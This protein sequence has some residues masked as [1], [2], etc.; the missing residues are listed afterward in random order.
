MKVTPAVKVAWRGLT[1]RFLQTAVIALVVLASTA[2]SALALGMIAD[3]NAPFDHAF[4]KDHGAQVA[5]T[6]DT[7]TASAAQL[8]ATTRLPGVTA[9][10]GPFPQTQVTVHIGLSGAA[11]TLE[12]QLLVTGRASPGGP[13]D[14]LSLDAGRWA[15]TTG[16]IVWARGRTSVPVR[17]GQKITVTGVPGSPQLTVV[18]IATSVTSTSQAW[19][20]PAEISA[21][22]APG[23]AQMLYRF[24]SAGSTAA[25][26]ADIAAV[27]AA[28]PSGA[29]LGAPQ[30]YLPVQQ[31]A[32]ADIAPWVP[33][34]VTFGVIALVMSVLIVI[35]VISGAV[36]GGMRRIGV[37]KSIGFTPL[38]VVAAYVL[39]VAIPALV[40]CVVGAV[41]GDLLSVPLLNLNG[42]VYGIG[43]LFIP[44]W[45]VVVVPLA[46]LA[47]TCAAATVPALRA[48]RM[49][50]VQAIATGRAPRAS[51]GFVA[52]RLL[53]RLTWVPRPVTIGLAEPFSRPARTLVTLAAILFGVVA[54]TF[55]V[56]LGT[57]LSRTATDLSL[58]R[59]EPVHVA[60]RA[61]NLTAGQQ[62]T[63]ISALTSQPGTLHDVTE[64]DDQIGVPGLSSPM[65]V[66]SYDG[67]ASWTGWSVITGRW[68]S[69]DGEADV[70]TYFLTATGTAVGDT[71]T[72]AS[73]GR[74]TTVR[75]VGEVFDTGNTADIFMS[76]AS[77][78]AVAPGLTP[79]QYD[80]GVR[81]GTDV[82]SYTNA[83]STTLGPSFD[84]TTK[85]NSPVFS[86]VITLLAVL[87]VLLIVVAGLG[88]LNTVVL[89]VRERAH[90]LGIFKAIGMTPRQTVGMVVCS[91]TGIGLV[92]G[93]I[94]IPAGVALH[95]YV[96]P[97][98]GH[99]AQ[100]AV[101]GSLLSVYAPSE[102]ALLALSG[103]LIAAA[104]ALG[105]ASWVAR[106]RT[107]TALRAE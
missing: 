33:F 1:G 92:A 9:A 35:N 11:G 105:P 10:A 56:G 15:K 49:S 38:G 102:L 43:V 44:I 55:G 32:A 58:A 67:D 89:Q 85:T 26:S 41:C 29:L 93:A 84:V 83:L 36:V 17:L 5:V 63:I 52:H 22:H 60:P 50:A 23:V 95:R 2:A 76:S 31:E 104:G 107:A 16:E 48:G 75:I 81:P 94:A 100:S 79:H 30:S 86:S 91:V 62:Q 70:N 3:T 37:L 20:L 82:Q 24:S 99:A 77:L 64:T 78:A 47:L 13:V 28:L 101:P 103:L 25:V 7:S 68:Y 80:V 69:G 106:I 51:H 40:G 6:A 97:I 39:Q 34:I 66:T 61:G 90:D 71:Y 27:R 18:G 65:S 54:V 98:M 45:V 14:D 59:T 42:A 74:Q 8:A 12:Q 96:V 19:V 21:L 88:V 53:G 73:G 4:V 72:L 46:M 87:I 57:S